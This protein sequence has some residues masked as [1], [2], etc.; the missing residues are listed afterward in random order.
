MSP[1]QGKYAYIT[2]SPAT[3]LEAFVILHANK[4]LGVYREHPVCKPTPPYQM[5]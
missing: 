5:Q 4:V 2:L 3:F 1:L